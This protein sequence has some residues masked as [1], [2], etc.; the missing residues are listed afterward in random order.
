MLKG[1]T[2]THTAAHHKAVGVLVRWRRGP[3]PL[4]SRDPGRQGGKEVG[5]VA[6]TRGCGRAHACAGAPWDDDV[7]YLFLQKQNLGAK[8]HIYL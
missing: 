1:K 5:L 3:D 6:R 7:F 8:L 2:H 4:R